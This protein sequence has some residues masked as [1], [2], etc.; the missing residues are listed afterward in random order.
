MIVTGITT[1]PIRQGE[2]TL[3]GFLDAFVHELK[4]G[5]VLAIT[6][7]VVS[8]CEGRLVKESDIDKAKLTE[9]ES[10][11]YL[12]P[13]HSSYGITLTITDGIL[14][15]TAG[16]DSSNGDGHYILWPEDSQATANQIRSYLR[17]RFGVD[18]AGVI[19]TDSKTTPLRRGTTGIALAHSGFAA[20]NEYVGTPD[21]FGRDMQV[22]QANVMDGLASA[23]VAV[24]GEGSEC[25]PLAIITEAEFVQFQENDPTPDELDR[26]KIPLEEDLY[27]PLIKT[28]PWEKGGQAK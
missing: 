6:S 17:K 28:A 2:Y 27:T 21:L 15:P 10:Q 20:L 7:K 1:K 4:G 9:K 14:I 8:I 19:I 22:T 12:P 23:A 25:T 3:E 18:K 11:Y 13:E 26:L 16:I 24:M 5:S